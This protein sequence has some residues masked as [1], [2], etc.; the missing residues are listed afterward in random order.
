M[1]I[2]V[3]EAVEI[4]ECEV[5]HGGTVGRFLEAVAV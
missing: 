2:W 4:K 3:K 5:M 1:I